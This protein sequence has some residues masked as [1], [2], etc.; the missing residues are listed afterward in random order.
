MAILGHGRAASGTGNR[1]T[2]LYFPFR[3]T[4]PFSGSVNCVIGG[5][6]KA[7]IQMLALGHLHSSGGRRDQRAQNISPKITQDNFPK[8]KQRNLASPNFC[9]A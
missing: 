6:E 3:Q 7:R 1:V 9:P 5:F 4:S 8:H 2:V